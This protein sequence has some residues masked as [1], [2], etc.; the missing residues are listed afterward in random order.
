MSDG[1]LASAINQ[2]E[3][4]VYTDAVSPWTGTD[5]SGALDPNHCAGWTVETSG[6]KG[7]RGNASSTYFYWSDG[8]V[9]GCDQINHLY[10]LSNVVQIDFREGFETADFRRWSETTGVP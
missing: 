10:C 9:V 4:G 5:D 2:N 6:T 7:L 8:P 3:Y 1:H